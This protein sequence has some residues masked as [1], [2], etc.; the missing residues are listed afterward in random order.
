MVYILE[1]EEFKQLLTQIKNH[2]KS[3]N[4]DSSP[5]LQTSSPTLQAKLSK[6]QA[7]LQGADLS[8]LSPELKEIQDQHKKNLNSQ[9]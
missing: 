1:V 2:H 8:N 4:P 5:T 9:S 7:S 3:G 6:L